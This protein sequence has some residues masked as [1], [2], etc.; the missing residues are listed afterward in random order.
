MP[1]NVYVFIGFMVDRLI[2][3]SEINL[4]VADEQVKMLKAFD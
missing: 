1:N 4:T 3:V 2:V